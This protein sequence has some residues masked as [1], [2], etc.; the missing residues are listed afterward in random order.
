MISHG[1]TNI[2]TS[3]Q[4]SYFDEFHVF[5]RREDLRVAFQLNDWFD[6]NNDLSEYLDISI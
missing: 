1:D 4:V 3:S 2:M 5:E 6:P